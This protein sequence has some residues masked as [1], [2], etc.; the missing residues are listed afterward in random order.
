MLPFVPMIFAFMFG[1]FAGL[2]HRQMKM[3]SLLIFVIFL[4]IVSG[5]ISIS[6]AVNPTQ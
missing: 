5:L 6:F 2:L 4:G 3:V 1:F